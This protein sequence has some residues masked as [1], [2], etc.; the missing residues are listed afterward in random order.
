MV[1]N[2]RYRANEVQK[3]QS[4]IK[5]DFMVAY[6]FLKNLREKEQTCTEIKLEHLNLY[7]G[8]E[9]MSQSGFTNSVF[10]DDHTVFQDTQGV[11]CGWIGTKT[12][13]LGVDMEV[14]LF[15]LS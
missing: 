3:L 10:I 8:S 12:Q 5:N 2:F 14:F 13:N 15:H 11:F 9:I 4:L 6:A 7:P 1:F